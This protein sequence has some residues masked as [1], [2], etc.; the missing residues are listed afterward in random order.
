MSEI[1]E[2]QVSDAVAYTNALLNMSE[3]EL[4]AYNDQYSEKLKIAADISRNFYADKVA[5]IKRE[6]VNKVNAAF[7]ETKSQL[8]QAGQ[9][10]IDGFIKGMTSGKGKLSKEVKKIANSIVKAMKKTLKINSPSKVFEKLGIY[11]GQGYGIGFVNSLEEAKK[12]ILSALPTDLKSNAGKGFTSGST[13]VTN[14]N[15]YQTNN[16]PKAL[17]RL[18]IYRQTKNQLAFAKGAS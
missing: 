2:M 7:A 17:S 10:A 9:Q 14:N 11:S 1:T 6:Y 8:R 13:Y 18:E 15:F 3:K 5:E 4:S 16:S 12:A